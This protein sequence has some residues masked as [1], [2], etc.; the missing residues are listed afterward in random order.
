MAIL[1]RCCCR[2]FVARNQI[3]GEGATGKKQARRLGVCWRA[4]RY[5]AG[6]VQGIRSRSLSISSLDVLYL[7][8]RSA[9][10]PRFASSSLIR[11]RASSRALG[12]SRTSS[13]T[14]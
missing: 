7:L 10:R 3:S 2:G 1:L 9:G 13:P 8:T 4:C 11:G 12:F 14:V 6:G 5:P